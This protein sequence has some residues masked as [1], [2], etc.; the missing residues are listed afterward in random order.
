[1]LLFKKKKFLIYGFGLS[2]KSCFNFLKKNNYI[3]IY[4][5][6]TKLISKKFKKYIISKKI[7]NQSKYDYIIISPGININNCSINQFLKKNKSKII[8]ELDVFY[9]NYLNNFKITI[10][11]TNGKSTTAKLLYDIMK[12]A[13]RDVRLVGNIGYPILNEKNIKSNTIFIIEASSYQIDYSKYFKTDYAIILNLSPDHLERHI[14]FLNYAKVKFKLIKN[15]NKNGYA[16]INKN[17]QILINMIKKLK[18]QPKIFKVNIN[19]N[20]NIVN[21]IKNNY[22]KNYNNLSNLTFAIEVLSK[23]KIKIKTSAILQVVNS[24]KGLKY[25]QEIISDKKDLLIINDSKSTSFSSSINL[26]KS[27]RNIYWILGGT[28]KLGDKFKLEKKYFPNIKSYIYGK[29]KLIFSKILKSKIK[30]KYFLNLKK[31]LLALKSDIRKDNN[32]KTIIFSPA[33]ASFDQFK[34]FEHRGKYFNLLTK[35]LKL[36]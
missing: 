17:E 24:F 20:K 21:K 12:K 1:M 9:C 14:T 18:I 34:N 5:D 6:N 2:G 7:L 11:G 8:N 26:L 35:K 29:D 32:K 22:F 36:I 27:Y 10:T 28:I 23:L 30:S 31:A 19:A 13:R 25:R 33:A 15:Q 3:D 16:F 4:D